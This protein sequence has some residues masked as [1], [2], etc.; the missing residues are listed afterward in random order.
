[1]KKLLITMTALSL[2]GNAFAAGMMADDPL[3]AKVSIDQLET[4][5]TDGDNPTVWEVDAWVGKD[6]NKLW[7]KSEGEVAGGE[8]EEAELQL[9][10]S[11]AISPFWDL[12][13]GWRRDIK[14]VPERDWLAI[15]VKG[16]APYLL[17]VDATLFVGESD[18][19]GARLQAEYEYMLSQKWVLSPEIEIN[20]HARDDEATGTGS[21]L[22]DMELG[23]RLRYEI[24]RE[25]APYIGVNGWRKYGNTADLAEAH[26]EETDDMQFVA[27]IRAWF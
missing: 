20:F 10:Y 18:Q 17:E 13:A 7:F 2:T 15:G 3:I 14:P 5:E 8:T 16:L 19:V 11:R 12:Q 27:G 4:R 21:G 26:G 22:S 25:F 1:M 23:L 9:L 6:L 24:R